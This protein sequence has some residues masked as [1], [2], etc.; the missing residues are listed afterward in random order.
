MIS[1]RSITHKIKFDKPLGDYRPI[2]PE[3]TL[4]L[5][6]WLLSQMEA[7]ARGEIAQT[8]RQA[9]QGGP[10]EQYAAMVAWTAL[11]KGGGPWDFKVDLTLKGFENVH[12]AGEW[13]F[14]D[15]VANIHYGYVGRA[16][17]FSTDALLNGAGVAQITSRTSDWSYWWSRFDD[18]A[19]QA[20]ILVGIYLWEQYRDQDLTEDMLR[21]ALRRYDLWLKKAPP[22]VRLIRSA[23]QP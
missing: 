13:Y 3:G 12:L 4:D 20:A 2:L 11:V 22:N 10:D 17:G 8:L 5:T 1:P 16:G 6:D 21:E 18:P 7:N 23:S 15:I 9:N 14:Y 19:D